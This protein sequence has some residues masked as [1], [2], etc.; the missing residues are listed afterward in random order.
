MEDYPYPEIKP[1]TN[2]NLLDPGVY[3]TW[4]IDPE[5]TETYVTSQQN[6]SDEGDDNKVYF[7]AS[8]ELLMPVTRENAHAE[9]W[10]Y[11]VSNGVSGPYS[12][13]NDKSNLTTTVEVEEI[14]AGLKYITLR[15]E[16]L[17]VS[18]Y[19]TMNI[20]IYSR[21]YGSLLYHDEVTNGKNGSDIIQVEQQFDVPSY[22]VIS[23]VSQGQVDTT[24]EGYILNRIEGV[25]ASTNDE[26][27]EPQ[28][29]RGSVTWTE[30]SD[31][32]GYE[33]SEWTYEEAKEYLPAGS[34]YL[35]ENYKYSY[36]VPGYPHTGN[37]YIMVE[38]TQG[39]QTTFLYPTVNNGSNKNVLA[40]KED[41]IDAIMIAND[42]VGKSVGTLTKDGD[43]A[44]V[45]SKE[46]GVTSLKAVI[47]I[48]GLKQSELTVDNGGVLYTSVQWVNVPNIKE[49]KD[50]FAIEGQDV[51]VTAQLFDKNDQKV[52][53][54]NQQITFFYLEDD[55]RIKIDLS[56]DKV[57]S[58][59]ALVDA[60]NKGA[61]D[62][63]GVVTITFRDVM[64]DQF[65]SRIEGLEASAGDYN[66][67]LTV[68]DAEYVPV[69]NVYWVDLGLTFVD[70]AVAA[71]DPARTTIFANEAGT[72]DRQAE[73]AVSDTNG[74]NVGYQVVADCSKFKFW[75]TNQET[76]EIE[77]V[78][79]IPMDIKNSFVDIKGVPI[80]Y[81]LDEKTA[82]LSQDGK[83]AT[84]YST[85]AGEVGLIGKIDLNEENARD[86]TFTY[87]NDKGEK[88]TVK[89]VGIGRPNSTG[90]TAL[91]L[92]THWV[93]SGTDV[94]II[95]PKNIYMGVERTVYVKVVDSYGNP[96][97]GA[98][99]Q[100][101]VIGVNE[102]AEQSAGVSDANGIARITL[103]ATFDV[104]D[105][106]STIRV[107]VM[108][109]INKSATITYIDTIVDPFEVKN[110]GVL[111]A[112]TIEV[113]FSNDIDL[114]SVT[115]SQFTLTN[116]NDMEYTVRSVAKGNTS[117]SVVLTLDEPINQMSIN[118]TLGVQMHNKDGIDYVLTDCY[119]QILEEASTVFK[120]AD[121]EE[122]N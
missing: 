54:P 5:K 10:E 15:F 49:T 79:D 74:W 34:G 81:E 99:V 69:A 70:S 59:A 85:R 18:K 114:E 87:I 50:Y 115:A 57:G 103:P 76:G 25:W 121:C 6:S 75:V 56:Q 73:Y 106:T 21:Q 43:I 78:V 52:A 122:T 100:Y 30:I 2:A 35:N 44:V 92:K 83:A 84:L 46:I 93:T 11:E 65:Y 89:N 113:Y 42:A 110:I 37:A 107:T 96:I 90:N 105:R 8:P 32:L 61:T 97:Q 51:T 7:D 119:G 1:G 45:D 108:D 16:K 116:E 27:S 72:I 20:D 28:P 41:G 47:N 26:W 22:L 80:A 63:N 12:I 48:E 55:N 111:D 4:Y 68:D 13:Y 104:T 38:D 33:K 120:P 94:E 31:Q 66:V 19:T 3:D 102:Q 40:P 98:P 64:N 71:D 60:T 95:A 82:K 67:R 23:L 39:N 101:A 117:K 24:S 88:V 9:R 14:P 53:T 29:I 62:G 58:F 112:N 118:H 109:S 77:P 36:K 17:D 91:L 86:V